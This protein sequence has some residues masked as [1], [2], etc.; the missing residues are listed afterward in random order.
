VVHADLD[1]FKN[2]ND[3]YGHDAGD[4]V[5]KEFAGDPP[6]NI[7]GH[8]IS[9]GEWAADE[10]LLVLSHVGQSD[11]KTAVERLR[12]RFASKSFSFDG[13]NMAVTCE[14]RCLWIPGQR[15][16]RNSPFAGAS[17]RYKA[18]IREACFAATRSKIESSWNSG[19]LIP[20]YPLIVV[21][22]FEL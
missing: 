11:I 19:L 7:R 5:L 14:F 9:A 22:S 4:Q 2:I 18:L 20:G 17:G 10:F 21:T 8:R 15:A 13:E 12:E 1:S 6:K 16:L 3:S